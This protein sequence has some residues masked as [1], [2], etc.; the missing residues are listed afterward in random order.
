M[1]AGLGRLEPAVL[2]CPSLQLS[3]P[4]DF[5][6]PGSKVPLSLHV[7]SFSGPQD[8]DLRTSVNPSFSL[9]SNLSR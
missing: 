4:P 8:L 9:T 1:W 6:T 3:G 2:I 5:L 7:A